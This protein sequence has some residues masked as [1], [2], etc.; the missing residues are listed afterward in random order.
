[1]SSDPRTLI[2]TAPMS[3]FQIVAVALCVVLNALD[4]FDVLA[5]TFAAPGISKEWE[6]GPGALGIVIS[7]GLA[8]MIVGSLFIAPMADVVGRRLIIIGC[9]IAMTIGM[10]LSATAGN[11][12]MLAAWRV[13]TG[14]G[15]GGMLGAIT[16]MAAEY[17]NLRYR[18]LAVS[19]MTVGYPMGGV[20]GGS[21]VAWML[22]YYE[23]RSVFIFGGVVSAVFLPLVLWRLPESIEFLATKR[24]PNA[25]ERIQ[26]I[27]KRMGHAEP[28]HL[29]PVVAADEAA[30]VFD[31]FKPE[32]LPRTL[33]VCSGYFLHMLTFYY[34]LGWIPTIVT[35]LGF[36]PSSGASVSVWMNLGGILSGAVFGYAARFVGLRVLSLI[37][38]LTGAALVVTF[39]RS[40]PD[41]FTLRALA[42]V[43]GFFMFGGV[44]CLYAAF[45]RVFP[46]HVRATGTGFVIGIG[47]FGG[48]LG[49]TLGGWLIAA[50]L[51][52][53]DSAAIIALGSVLAAFAMMSL[54]A[55]LVAAPEG[56]RAQ[57]LKSS[58][59]AAT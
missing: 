17:A 9:L 38:M 41:L 51:G 35:S 47:R 22:Q 46:T 54:Q 31:I 53:A 36:A 28:V 33:A 34:L 55:S 48:M 44:V 40:P 18:N 27:L 15:M 24:P 56:K 42:F 7:T 29:P 26:G 6:L 3:S 5:I 39:G 30:R 21:A 14:I 52:R 43:L 19:I 16:A 8:G 59:N 57:P 4:G 58:S 12:Y 25:L 11:V 49:P 1:M 37:A 45:A 10:L 2:A 20:L 50:G 23:W 32:L 13:L